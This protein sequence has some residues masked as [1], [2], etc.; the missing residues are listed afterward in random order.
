MSG[1]VKDYWRRTWILNL[2]I[3]L[4]VLWGVI[5]TVAFKYNVFW[6]YFTLIIFLLFTTYIHQDI[7][8]RFMDREKVF[9]DSNG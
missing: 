7:K 3:S 8:K 6:L 5:R 1:F 4:I 9:G 2:F